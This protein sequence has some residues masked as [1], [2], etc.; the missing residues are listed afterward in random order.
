[1][2]FFKGLLGELKAEMNKCVDNIQRSSENF[3]NSDKAGLFIKRQKY[4]LI[5]FNK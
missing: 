5:D 3:E 4:Y 2:S 1:M